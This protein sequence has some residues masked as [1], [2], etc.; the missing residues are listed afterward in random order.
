MSSFAV[1]QLCP[2]P[3]SGHLTNM[4]DPITAPTPPLGAISNSS[5]PLRRHLRFYRNSNTILTC[6][7]TL[8][9]LTSSSLHNLLPAF[10]SLRRSISLSICTRRSS[11]NHRHMHSRRN[12]RSKY[13]QLTRYSLLSRL[14]LDYHRKAKQPHHLQGNG[15]RQERPQTLA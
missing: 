2:I 15:K 6:R 10:N 11:I 13:N 1:H 5:R 9:H 4:T 12:S 8:N 7:S 14:R 3:S